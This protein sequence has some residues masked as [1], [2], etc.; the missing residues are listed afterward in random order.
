MPVSTNGIS[1]TSRNEQY[2][3]GFLRL[4]SLRN[5][6]LTILLTLS[7]TDPTPYAN[8]HKPDYRYCRAQTDSR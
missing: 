6:P 8:H 1:D 4:V 5:F 3:S 2:F 7:H